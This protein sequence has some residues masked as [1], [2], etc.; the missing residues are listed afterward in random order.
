MFD[1]GKSSGVENAQQHFAFFAPALGFGFGSPAG[2]D[3][4]LRNLILK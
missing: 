3:A 2:A 4:L 1:W